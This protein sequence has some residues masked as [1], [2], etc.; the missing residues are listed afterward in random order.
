HGTSG[1]YLVEEKAVSYVGSGREIVRLAP[2]Q[3]GAKSKVHT[4]PPL[5][6]G[7]PDFDLDLPGSSLREEARA[8]KSESQNAKSEI[9]QSLLTSAATKSISRSARGLKFAPLP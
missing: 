7:D 5:V 3:A 8:S 9:G 4:T 6:M 1:K 2:A